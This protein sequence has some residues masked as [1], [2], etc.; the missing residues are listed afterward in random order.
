M[1]S[2]LPGYEYDIFISY[3]QND[4]KRDGWVSKFVQ[5]LKDE[6]EATLKNPVSIYFDENP[7]DGLLET[8]QVDA[9]LEK[10][11][12]CLVFIPI[13]SQ[14]YCDTKSFAWQHEFLPFNNMASEDE[15]GMKITL[16]NGNVVSRVLPIKIHDLDDH[17][18]S[19]LEKELGGPLRS[20]DFIYKEPGVNRPLGPDDKKE[21]NLNATSYKNQINKVANA[22]KEIGAG[23]L[24]TDNLNIKESYSGEK[25][26]K[27]VKPVTDSNSKVSLKKVLGLSFIPIILILAYYLFVNYGAIP[28]NTLEREKSIAVIPF[29]NTKPDPDTDYLGFAIA[30]QI[31]GE[32]GH[33][34][35]LLVR[36]STAVRKYD[37]QTIDTEIV[38]DELKVNFLLA[39]NYLI[40]EEV[41]RLNIELIEINSNKSIWRE[42]LKVDFDNAFDL[43]DMVTQ[44]VVDQL[45]VQ[46]T[47][48]A[49]KRIGR[50]VSNNPLAYEYYLRSLSYPRNDDGDQLAIDML[51]KSIELD[52]T[53]APTYNQ[54]GDRITHL[55]QF[56]LLG[57]EETKKGENFFL[58]ALSLN[59]ESLNTLSNL[60][61]LYTET[62][63]TSEA[64]EIT[65]RVLDINPNNAEARFSLGYIYRYAGMLNESVVE[66]KRAAVLDPSNSLFRSLGV[67]YMNQG[68]YNKALKALDVNDNNAHYIGWQGIVYARQGKNQQAIE[69]FDQVIELNSQKLWSLVATAIKSHLEGNTEEGLLAMNELE[70]VNIEDAEAWYFWGSHYALMGDKAGYVR[71][72]QRALDKGYFNYPFMLIDPFLNEIQ[73]DPEFQE[74]LATAKEKH[75]AFKKEFFE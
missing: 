19:I 55:A 6:I 56:G 70:K 71:C 10:K 46:F 25:E 49:I 35:N 34:K 37:Q 65:R 24:N 31:I 72:F 53:Y 36:P 41:I 54:L 9:T 29:A 42:E 4:N 1:P 44:K 66:M 27:Y 22:L 26:Y 58:K 30:N 7:H 48:E 59:D 28:T 38:A 57:P 2:I 75:E 8:H 62:A 74:I 43:Q 12:K 14:T 20:I 68:E 21:D 73:D 47:Q 67:T 61:M 5:A 51:Y 50:D 15:L 39:G 33:N 52:S 23:V 69:Y 63:R 60:A 18:Q 11:L 45:D 17:D 3:R 40:V 16:S 13:I 32:L 64:V